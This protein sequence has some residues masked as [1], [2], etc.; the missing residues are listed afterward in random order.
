M[1]LLGRLL[2]PKEVDGYE[3]EETVR[4]AGCGKKMHIPKEWVPTGRQG[5]HAVEG[6]LCRACGRGI[7]SE[8]TFA[9][10]SGRFRCCAQV[11]KEGAYVTGYFE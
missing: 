5:G 1:N 2:G 11:T 8:C 7:C 10:H 3:I 4:C 6:L 9:F